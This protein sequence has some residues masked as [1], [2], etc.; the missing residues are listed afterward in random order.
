MCITS[1]VSEPCASFSEVNCSIRRGSV[2]KTLSDV[3]SG[4]SASAL[5]QY[6]ENWASVGSPSTNSEELQPASSTRIPFSCTTCA[7]A[8][9]AARLMCFGRG[10]CDWAWIESLDRVLEDGWTRPR[11]KVSTSCLLIV[12]KNSASSVPIGCPSQIWQTM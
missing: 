12:F 6:A 9:A 5:F 2:A 8:S 4:A 10:F 7:K 11:N 3:P 1:S